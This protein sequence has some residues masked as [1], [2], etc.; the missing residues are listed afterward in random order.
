MCNKT[1]NHAAAELFALV[2]RVGGRAGGR[3]AAVLDVKL[4]LVPAFVRSFVGINRKVTNDDERGRGRGRRMTW[5]R[6]RDK[7]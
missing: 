4:A 1:I 3:A 2:R 5:Q 6:T 7:V